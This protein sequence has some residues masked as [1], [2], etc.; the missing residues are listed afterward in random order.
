MGELTHMKPLPNRMFCSPDSTKA[1]TGFLGVL[2]FFIVILSSPCVFASIGTFHPRGSERSADELARRDF[3]SVCPPF[4][5]LDESG[6]V[7]DPV[8]GIND[9]RPYSPEKTCGRCHDYGLITSAYHFQQGKGE[10]LSAEFKAM[11]PW[12]RTPGQYGG[13]Y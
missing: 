11:Y 5:L 13:R 8:R 6:Q 10:K 1:A 3:M 4:F 2:A 9:K 12:M 7:I